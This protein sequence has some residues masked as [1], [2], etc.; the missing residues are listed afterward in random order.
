MMDRWKEELAEKLTE[1]QE[2]AETR[3]LRQALYP[4]RTLSELAIIF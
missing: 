1:Q 3:E 2:G 4:I